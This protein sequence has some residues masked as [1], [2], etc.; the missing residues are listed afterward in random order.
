ME[1]LPKEI[2]NCPIEEALVEIRFESDLPSNAIFGIL[3]ER[4]KAT[5]PQV[6]DLPILQIPEHIRTHDSAL[7]HKPYH[8]LKG[9]GYVVQIGPKVLGIS[10]PR[11]YVGWTQFSERIYKLIKTLQDTEI[12]SKYVRVGLR[13]INFFEKNIFNHIRLN[14]MMGDTSL[15]DADCVFRTS[16]KK[17]GL[18]PTLQISNM[19]SKTVEGKPVKG[20]LLD[21][22]S[23]VDPPENFSNN[24]VEIIT[25][26]HRIE[27]QLFFELLTEE[28]T[29]E[30]EPVYSK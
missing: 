26:L 13:Y 16:I 2:K 18:H 29:Q 1:Q 20:S 21:I 17:E 10:S 23:Y 3:Y 7:S 15:S 22:D 4:L 28:F 8:L 11:P 12:I 24:Y 14:I 30:L 6:E 19:A 9:D 27:K 5:Y 25:K